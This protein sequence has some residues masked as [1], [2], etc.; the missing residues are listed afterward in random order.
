VFAECENESPNGDANGQAISYYGVLR[1]FSTTETTNVPANVNNVALASATMNDVISLAQG[2]VVGAQYNTG[3]R[4]AI[5]GLMGTGVSPNDF[6]FRSR[7]TTEMGFLVRLQDASSGQMQ[8]IQLSFF[9]SYTFQRVV[10][11]LADP[12]NYTFEARGTAIFNG[13]GVDIPGGLGFAPVNYML[14]ITMVGGRSYNLSMQVSV[15]ASAFDYD[16]LAV[17]DASNSFYWGGMQPFISSTGTVTS[18]SLYSASGTNWLESFAP[19]P[20]SEP[21][22]ILYLALGLAA[23]VLRRLR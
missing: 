22:S 10:P 1:A 8:S 20:V 2:F 16:G 19:S 9:Q 6:G 3:I 4:L 18:G 15:R 12:R 7:G 11:D 23:I 21:P 14:P 13:A 5:D 17:S